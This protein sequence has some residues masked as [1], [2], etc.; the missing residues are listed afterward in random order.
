M[1]VNRYILF[2]ANI[3]IYVHFDLI[4]SHLGDRDKMLKELHGLMGHL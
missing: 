3:F 4:Q 2:K 1:L